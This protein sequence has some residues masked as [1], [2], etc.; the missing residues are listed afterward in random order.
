MSND[1]AVTAITLIPKSLSEAKELTKE[2]APAALL[3]AALK[4]RPADL[5]AIVMTGAEL[6]LAP[7]Q[8][9][10]GIHIIEGKPS[11]SAD[12]MAGIVL[13][14]PKCEA[15]RVVEST[16]ERVTVLAKRTG[17]PEVKFSFSMKDAERAGLAGK[18][19]WR[20]Y[21]RNMMRA[22]ATAAACRA[23]WPDLLMGIYSPEELAD[24]KE[25]NAPPM[26]TSAP[27]PPRPSPVEAQVVRED[28]E[29]IGSVLDEAAAEFAD[30]ARETP[31]PALNPA[32]PSTPADPV[33]EMQRAIAE[34]KDGKALA[35]LGTKLIKLPAEKRALVM[36]QYQARSKELGR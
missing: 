21:P 28:A 35:A 23:V 33:A 9:I 17:Q 36:P 6:G 5:L 22:R 24:E 31:S 18:G 32:A 15:L 27:P 34:A 12:A 26:S 10:R 30:D 8:S 2:L 13:A 14:S 16:E 1:T 11:L 29:R 4:Q 7:M 25:V 19:N 20:S 3:P